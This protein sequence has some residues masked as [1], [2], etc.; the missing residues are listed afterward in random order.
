MGQLMGE[1]RSKREIREAIAVLEGDKSV[2]M[3]MPEVPLTYRRMISVESRIDEL[4]WVIGE[5]DYPDTPPAH[6]GDDESETT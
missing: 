1:M 3:D 6:E 2:L 5:K 4:L